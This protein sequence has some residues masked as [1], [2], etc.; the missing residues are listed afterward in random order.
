MSKQAI[1]FDCDGV[2]IDSEIISARI[3]RRMLAEIGHEISRDVFLKTFLGRSFPKVAEHIRTHFGAPLPEDFERRYRAN[4]LE[5]FA[6]ELKPMPGIMPVLRDLQVKSCVA[7]SSSPE[8]ARRSLEIV[9]LDRCFGDRLF[10]ASMVS[11]GKPAPDLFLHAAQQM[12]MTPDQCLVIEDSSTGIA[13]AQAAGMDVFHFVG[14]AHLQGV[15]LGDSEV[16]RFDHWA[17]FAQLAPW[18]FEKGSKE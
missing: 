15:D 16:R 3:L 10:T 14:G 4:L 5:A 2:L 9:G 11:R 1:I 13:A 12:A 18:A 8:R 6:A 17:Q 7:T